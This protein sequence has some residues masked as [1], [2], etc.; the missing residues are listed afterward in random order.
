[1]RKKVILPVLLA[2]FF[3]FLSASA[4]EIQKRVLTIDDAVNVALK[5]S[6]PAR[7][8]QQNYQ[9]ARWDYLG[10]WSN[11]LP[12]LSASSGWTRNSRDVL[13]LRL[14]QLVSS[15][16]QYSFNLG[17]NQTVFNGG[18]NFA[19]FN[20]KRYGK[21]S[22]RDDLRLAEQSVALNVKQGCYDLL[23]SQM[24]YDV[25]KDAVGVSL[26]QLK[27][28]KARYDLGAASLSDY[29]KAKVQ[30]GNDSLTLITNENNVK[31]AEA[32]LNNLLGLDVNTPLEINARLEYTKFDFDV[33]QE[34]KRAL[35]S[36]PQI[37]KA[38]MGLNQSRSGLTLA[39]SANYP[40]VSF[41]GDYSWSDVVFPKSSS[42]WDKF[43]SW[44]IGIRISLSIFDG[45]LTTGNVRSAKAQV[46]L[47]QD[48]LEQNKRD[49]A[50][51]IKQAY[52]SVKEGE[53]KIQLTND[54]LTSAEEDLKLTQEKYNLGAAS[55]L[56]LLNAN[57]SYKTAKNNQVQA[58]YDYNLAVA[59]FQKAT[60]R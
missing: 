45:F 35:E 10:G 54:A 29:L 16:D 40:S 28:A 12:S 39:R 2:V 27:M 21:K 14:G 33:D 46:K 9:S 31:L 47:N 52:V 20:L 24:L 55:I 48:N 38:R 4:Q 51:A 7:S 15:Q 59:Q 17:L 1:M 36:H 57:V 19:S 8:A 50:L 6:F 56:D 32:A 13:R 43:D 18:A 23:K 26:E 60:A 53:Q 25:Q 49:L 42:D 30:L 58:L 22:A 34:T 44:D 3:W 11:L 5:N 41:F 37:D